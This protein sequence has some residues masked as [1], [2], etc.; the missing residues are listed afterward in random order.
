MQ[1]GVIYARFS[2][3]MQDPNSIEMQLH[4]T[5]AF[6]EKNDIQIIADPYIDEAETGRNA[7]RASFLRMFG[8]IKTGKI[9]P[10][11][12]LIYK[13]ARFFRNVALWSIYEERLAQMGVTFIS[14]TEPLPDNEPLA[15]LQKTMIRA[16]DEFTSDNIGMLSLDGTKQVVRNGYWS[17][18][19][20]PFGFNNKKIPNREGYTRKGKLVERGTLVPSEREAGIVT[21]AFEIQAETGKGGSQVYRQLVAETGGPI[22]GRSGTPLGAKGLNAILSDPIYK[23]IVIYNKYGYR[24]VIDADGRS[25]KQRY[26]KPRDQW[27]IVSNEAWRLVSNELWDAAQKAREVNRRYHPGFGSGNKRASYALTGL[28]VCGVCGNRCGGKWQKSRNETFSKN[29]RYY[30]YRCR[31]AMDG[32]LECSNHTKIRGKELEDA[33]IAALLAQLQAEEL[34]E[35][36]AQEILRLRRQADAEQADRQEIEKRRRQ[37]EAEIGRLVEL[38]AKVGGDLDIIANKVADCRRELSAIDGQLSRSGKPA[39]IVP[40]DRLKPQIAAKLGRVRDLFRAPHDVDALRCLL[41]QWIDVIRID[42]DG[43]VLVKWKAA[44]VVELLDLPPVSEMASAGSLSTHFGYSSSGLLDWQPLALP[45]AG[46]SGFS[47]FS[48][49]ATPAWL[50]LPR[51]SGFSGYVET[52]NLASGFSG[53]SGAQ[54]A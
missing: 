45:A 27:V 20:A 48:P 47:G 12:I 7:D 21:R 29:S 40:I 25:R 34:I 53:F 44:A 16:F 43:K 31:G 54:V 15:Q 38:A 14:V 17:G 39:E 11:V 33:V 9:K 28:I 50:G 26:S 52:G 51:G 5:K 3:D 8:E 30:Y 23:G 1:Y 37:V 46:F 42:G 35:N 13:M 22:L 4:A 10:N 6:A 36:I 24:D 32:S 19:P 49:A 2:S 41:R 18:G